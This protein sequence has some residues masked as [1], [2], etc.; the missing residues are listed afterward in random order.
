ME[1]T[2]SVP[3][4]ISRRSFHRRPDE[5]VI[6]T[7]SVHIASPSCVGVLEMLILIGLHPLNRRNNLTIVPKLVRTSSKCDHEISHNGEG[8]LEILGCPLLAA[9]IGSECSVHLGS[10]RR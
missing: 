4:V 7:F 6:Q 3:A 9:L 10:G 8:A 5:V 2:R 1:W